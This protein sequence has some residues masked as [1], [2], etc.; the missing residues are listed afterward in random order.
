M[1]LSFL[2][3]PLIFLKVLASFLTNRSISIKIN[4]VIGPSFCPEAGVPQ[5][6]PDSPDL[7][8]VTTLPLGNFRSSP[9]TFC[10]WYADDQTLVV[11]SQGSSASMH[12]MALQ[13]AINNQN[14]FERRRGIITCAEKSKI[15]PIGH[16]LTRDIVVEGPHGPLTYPIL[17]PGE[18]TKILGLNV[19]RT[20]LVQKH[21]KKSAQIANSYLLNFNRMQ[22]LD[23]KGR[24]L[25]V[26]SLIIPTLTYPCTI[27]STAAFS[28]ILKLQRICNK[29]LKFVLKARYPEVHTAKSLHVR[30]KMRPI[31]KIIHN[32]SQNMWTKIVEGR[33]ADPIAYGAISQL[34]LVKAA[35]HFP[36]SEIFSRKEEPPSVFTNVC[37]LKPRVQRYYSKDMI[38]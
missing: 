8:N 10:P 37:R 26:K 34:E 18:T 14:D 17:P 23:L 16:Q 2:S 6:A 27:L 31:N 29:A 20:S 9:N 3:L 33:A 7:F 25:L 5:G 24:K 13:R 32:R 22:G 1:L 15:I 35:Y 28:N 11:A 30:A 21:V 4:G 19:Q 12:R 38:Q 36:S